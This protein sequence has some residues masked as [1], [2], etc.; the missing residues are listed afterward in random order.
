VT[1]VSSISAAP[2]RAAQSQRQL[3]AAKSRDGNVEAIRV[4]GRGQALGPVDQDQDAE[5]DPAPRWRE[6][7]GGIKRSPVEG[8][9]EADLGAG[10][11]NSD[12][13]VDPSALARLRGGR[14]GR[15]AARRPLDWP[16]RHRR[17][18]RGF[19]S[20]G[21]GHFL[22]D[23][24]LID[25]WAHR[26]DTERFDDLRAWTP[27]NTLFAAQAAPSFSSAQRSGFQKAAD[28]LTHGRPARI[29]ALGAAD[30][31]RRWR[32]H[33]IRPMPDCW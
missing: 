23:E 3:G 19:M 12:R 11:A 13:R 22:G 31:R 33:V 14:L 18:A 30:D 7:G 10:A 27:V 8:V 5:P 20:L 15:R 9:L 17:G 21:V 1:L 6:P 24:M 16:S 26:P 4:S 29:G 25:V 28:D 2:D 32:A